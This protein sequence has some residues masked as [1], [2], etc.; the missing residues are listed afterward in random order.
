MLGL[1]IGGLLKSLHNVMHFE[2]DQGTR[3]LD[4][5]ISCFFSTVNGN[6]KKADKKNTRLYLHSQPP[7]DLTSV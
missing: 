5:L 4:D 2:D 6:C 7:A 3:P 1:I